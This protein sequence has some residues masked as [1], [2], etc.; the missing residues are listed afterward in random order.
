LLTVTFR[1][2]CEKNGFCGVVVEGPAPDVEVEAGEA[3]G[4]PGWKGAAL[5][6]LLN[7]NGL[8]A[9]LS[10]L[11][12]SVEGVGEVASGISCLAVSGIG[13]AGGLGL[14]PLQGGIAW[15][16]IIGT[17]PGVAG[18]LAGVLLALGDMAA[19]ALDSKTC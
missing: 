9:G 18:A 16:F 3:T 17:F 1:S 19:F 8:E 15:I 14:A 10:F 6:A 5:T 7:S 4:L 2:G 12:A 13:T 11:V